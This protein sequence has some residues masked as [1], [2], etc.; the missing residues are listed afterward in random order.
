ML[1]MM[2]ASGPEIERSTCV[3]AAKLTI[4]SHP[5]TASATATGSSIAPWTKRILVDHVVQVLAPP[6]VGQLVEHG[7]LVAVLAHAQAHEPRADET[8]ATADEQPHPA[9]RSSS[10]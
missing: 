4:A 7:H 1:V 10:R 9:A 6:R 8:G 3:S 2:N 5:S